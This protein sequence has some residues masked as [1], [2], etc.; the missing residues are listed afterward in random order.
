MVLFKNI[1]FKNKVY[2]I[3]F[4]LILVLW[5]L[6][7]VVVGNKTKDMFEA[8]TGEISGVEYKIFEDSVKYD[9]EVEGLFHS[10]VVSNFEADLKSLYGVSNK[11]I[12]AK[13]IYI[14]YADRGNIGIRAYDVSIGGDKF[15]FV[16]Y[17][18]ECKNTCTTMVWAEKEGYIL[19]AKYVGK[20]TMDLYNVI[21]NPEALINKV[22][23]SDG[24]YVINY[25][26]AEQ[27]KLSL[28]GY[29][30]D[31]GDSVRVLHIQKSMGILGWKYKVVVAKKG[32]E[33]NTS[34]TVAD[35][36]LMDLIGKAEGKLYINKNINKLMGMVSKY[37]EKHRVEVGD[38]MGTW[39]RD[40]GGVSIIEKEGTSIEMK[41]IEF[42]TNTGVKK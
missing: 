26:S 20:D 34:F 19:N 14:D 28:N 22:L 39:L 30:E 36:E 13:R 6:S 7:G 15:G 41:K 2:V 38:K 3:L 5:Y 23:E 21:Y 31:A 10:V 1:K 11:D 25:R 40:G 32:F 29:F 17:E 33:L 35:G 24:E 42:K 8:V 18:T 9:I 12:V 27:P 4:S 37:L 16:R